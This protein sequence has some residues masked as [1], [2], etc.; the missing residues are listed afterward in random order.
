VQ[1]QGGA[2]LQDITG[3][4]HPHVVG[5]GEDPRAL[6]VRE[7]L[8]VGGVVAGG[9]RAAVGDERRLVRRGLRLDR[10]RAAD[11]ATGVRR[12]R[13]ARDDSEEGDER[14]QHGL[15]VSCRRS[16]ARSPA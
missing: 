5:D 3:A 14:A 11:V 2:R 1:H 15:H 16:T 4:K 7:E 10:V 9:E 8:V 12:R 6:Q 13:Q